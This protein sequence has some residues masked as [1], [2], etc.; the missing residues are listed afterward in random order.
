MSI[1]SN[2]QK[3]LR[4]KHKSPVWII[5]DS[6]SQV[7]TNKNVKKG[8][9]IK[10]L[11]LYGATSLLNTIKNRNNCGSGQVW[12]VNTCH[13]DSNDA[14]NISSDWIITSKFN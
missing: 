3:N 9:R 1:C 2:K 7:P 4:I 5:L 14:N 13:I 12:S 6:N 10:L 11:N 8:D